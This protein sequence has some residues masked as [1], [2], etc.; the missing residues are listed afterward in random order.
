MIASHRTTLVTL[1]TLATTATLTM[2]NPLYAQTE[3]TQA[4]PA[5]NAEAMAQAPSRLQVTSA[6]E[7]VG[8]ELEG[9]GGEELGEIEYLMINLQSGNVGYALVG[10]GEFFEYSE[11]LVAV[12]WSAI[13][14]IDDDDFQINITEEQFEQAPKITEERIAELTEPAVITQVYEYFAQPTEGET[15]E[16]AE[17]D[18]QQSTQEPGDQSYVMVGREIVTMVMP[19]AMMPAGEITGTEVETATGEEVGEVDKLMLDVNHG[20]VAYVLLSRGGFLG[21][22]EEWIP[23]PLGAL[24]WSVEEENLLLNVAEEQLQKIEALP[25]EDLP[26]RVRVDH[27]QTLYENYGIEPYWQRMTRQQQSAS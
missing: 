1:V 13:N 7:I 5:D 16:Q 22:G 6:D 24:Q 12:P 17:T 20:Q 18:A 26:T 14:M 23:V 4:V 21:F 25:K 15:E 10:S 9:V 11:E 3:Q 19:P 8:E 2:A 27:L